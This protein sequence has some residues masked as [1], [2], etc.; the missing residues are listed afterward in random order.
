M[1]IR[2]LNYLKQTKKSLEAS[3]SKLQLQ[4]SAARVIKIETPRSKTKSM[5]DMKKLSLKKL[6]PFQKHEQEHP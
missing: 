3:L 6:T 1:L 5:T 4:L 2:E